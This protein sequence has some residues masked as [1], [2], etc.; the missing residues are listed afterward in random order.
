MTNA[1]DMSLALRWDTTVV[2]GW[3]RWPLSTIIVGTVLPVVHVFVLTP[4]QTRVIT[5]TIYEAFQTDVPAK[6]FVSS[7]S[8][9]ASCSRN[10][11]T[12][13]VQETQHEL[14]SNRTPV[15]VAR[16]KES[17]PFI[18]DKSPEGRIACMSYNRWCTPACDPFQGYPVVKKV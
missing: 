10:C 1:C 4:A 17:H 5:C 3:F 13:D 6:S 8:T 18:R 12:V 16:L 15:L 11:L 9:S 7:L 2:C 14:L